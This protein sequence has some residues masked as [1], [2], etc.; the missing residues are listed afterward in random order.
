MNYY[1]YCDRSSS[2]EKYHE[3]NKQKDRRKKLYLY[4]TVL[5]LCLFILIQTKNSLVT[6]LRIQ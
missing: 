3:L 2:R 5:L 4:A 6:D 1:D